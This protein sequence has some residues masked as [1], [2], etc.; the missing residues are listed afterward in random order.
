MAAWPSSF[1]A[2]WRLQ[3]GAWLRL[4]RGARSGFRPKGIG[5]FTDHGEAAR[6]IRREFT[7][8]YHTLE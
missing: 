6:R 8:A 3:A 5:L 7:S 4:R 2:P 1:L